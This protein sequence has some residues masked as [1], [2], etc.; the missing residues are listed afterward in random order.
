MCWLPA[1]GGATSLAWHGGGGTGLAV[2][3]L[4]AASETDPWRLDGDGA[5]LVFAPSGPSARSG[6]A[7]SGVD[8]CDQLCVVTGTLTVGGRDQE[9]DCVGWRS[10]ASGE[11]DLS[12]IDSLRQ[13]YGWFDQANGIGVV[14][15]RPRKSRGHDADLIA[16]VVLE[17]EPAPRVTD[18]RLSSTYDAAGVPARVG[19]ELWLEEE[20]PADASEDGDKRRL[21]RRAAA[22]GEAIGEALT[23]QVGDFQLQALSLHWH[24]HGRDGIGVYL[25]GRRD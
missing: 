7:E 12:A 3:E 1:E 18:P 21:P 24:G 13:T 6:S 19:L 11:F 8:S 22:A 15:L 10:R 4:S 2:A 5:A 23:W 20:E 9:I 25:L 17:P 16:A 14:A